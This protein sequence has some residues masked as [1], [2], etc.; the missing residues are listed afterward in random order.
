[1]ANTISSHRHQYVKRK[2]NK[3]TERQRHRVM[4]PLC[5]GALK[6][7][8]CLMVTN[9]KDIDLDDTRV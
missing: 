7:L 1:M 4:Y 3:Q 2:T 5:C 6:K 9:D 8:V